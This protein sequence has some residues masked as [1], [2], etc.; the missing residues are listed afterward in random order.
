[1]NIERV[2]IAGG[3]GNNI[4]DASASTI[5]SVGLYGADGNDTLIG[6]SKDDGIYGGAGSDYLVGGAGNDV[7][8][9]YLAGAGSRATDPD[10]DTLT[11]GAGADTFLLGIDKSF[12]LGTGS[13]TITDFSIAAGDKIQLFGD[14]YNF[15]LGSFGGSGSIQ[16]TAICK[17]SDLIGV[18]QDVNVIGADVFTYYNPPPIGG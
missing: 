4:I 7:I 13:A 14:L 2:E 17:G 16:D 5:E 9:G 18:V 6:S 3:A 10:N 15:Q 8:S 12:Y 1:M 11:G